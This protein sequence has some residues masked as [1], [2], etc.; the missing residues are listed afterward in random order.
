MQA[1]LRGRA[2]NRLHDRLDDALAGGGVHSRAVHGRHSGALAARIRRHHQRGDSDF[3]ASSRSRSRRCCAAASCGRRAPGRTH[4]I[5]VRNGSSKACARVR[6]DAPPRHPPS[7]PDDAGRRRHARRDRLPVRAGAE[8]IHSQ[9]GH[10]PDLRLLP[11]GRRTSPST[12]WCGS[13]RQ[14]AAILRADPEC[15]G[16]VL[17]RR[18]GRF[19]SSGNTGRIFVRLKPRGE[20]KLSPDQ[21]IE[22]LRPK[23]NAIPGSAAYLQ[24]PPLIRIGGQL[25]K[26]LYQFTLQ[27]TDIAELYRASHG[28]RRQDARCARAA[29]RRQR[30]ADLESAGHRGYRSRPRL[31]AGRHGGPDRERALQRL[32]LAAGFHDLHADQ[33]ILGDHGSAAG[34]SARSRRARPALRRVRA[35]ASWCRS[36]AWRSCAWRRSADGH[37]PRPVAV[38]DD[39]LQPAAGRFAGRRRSIACRTVAREICRTRQHDLSGHGRGVPILAAGHGPAAGDGDPRDL[40]RARH[41]VR[42]FHPSDHDSVR[43]AVGRTGRAGDAADLS[44]RAEHLLLRRASSC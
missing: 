16:L 41:S 42:K 3:R 44:R 36:A 24:N 8:R 7:P 4:S 13:S 15:R 12:G 20:R 34:I 19:S 33:R 23:L 14:V 35:G 28:P 10:R 32:R 6:V 29:G 9:P 26:S 27:G 2:R 1:A 30:P 43:P 31:P 39:F 22:E 38:R 5:A 37:A 25:T 17:Q 18:C 40:H 21:V 11:K